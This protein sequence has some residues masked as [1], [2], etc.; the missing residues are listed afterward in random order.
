MKQ[1]ILSCMNTFRVSKEGFLELFLLIP[2]KYNSYK[3]RGFSLLSK[4]FASKIYNDD[5]I[6]TFTILCE[7]ALRS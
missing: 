7:N 4:Q 6:K 1:Y 3:C 2:C 5:K